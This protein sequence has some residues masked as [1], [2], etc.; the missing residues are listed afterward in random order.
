MMSHKSMFVVMPYLRLLKITK[1]ERKDTDALQLGGIHV[2]I[3]K[4]PDSPD[5]EQCIICQKKGKKFEPLHSG[6]N[7]RKRVRDVAVLKDDIVNKR[8]KILGPNY[9]QISQYIHMLQT[10]HRYIQSPAHIGVTRG[11][12]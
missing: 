12:F 9:I 7:E 2:L 5:L 1:S 6:G 11:T 4:S 8:L 10:I 3:S